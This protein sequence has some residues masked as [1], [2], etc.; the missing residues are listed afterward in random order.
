MKDCLKYRWCCAEQRLPE[1]ASPRELGEGHR[2]WVIGY[3]WNQEGNNRVQQCRVG[4]APAAWAMPLGF[5][6]G[7]VNLGTGLGGRCWRVFCRRLVHLAGG[8]AAAHN[9]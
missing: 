6:W 5:S 3:A 1:A 7:D 4:A 8:L 2:D 9:S